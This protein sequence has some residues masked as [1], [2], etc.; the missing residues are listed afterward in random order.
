MARLKF[1]EIDGKRYPWHD[2]LELRRAPKGICEGGS[3]H[4]V[5]A[6]RGRRRPPADRMAAGRYLEPAR[7]ETLFIILPACPA[8][9][10]AAV[11]QT[12][13]RNALRR[14]SRSPD[15]RRE[16]ALTTARAQ[17]MNRDGKSTTEHDGKDSTAGYIT[18]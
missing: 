4:P 8:A 17:K 5:R 11:N 14:C 3:A 1:I 18:S 13:S 12:F 7:L 9:S 10:P 6:A 16:H 2:I 15:G